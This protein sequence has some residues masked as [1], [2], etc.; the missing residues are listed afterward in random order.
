MPRLPVGGATAAD[1]SDP[2]PTRASRQFTLVQALRGLAALWVVL[3]HASATDDFPTLEAALPAPVTEWLFHAG[4]FGVAI[5][6]ALSGFVIA[7]SLRSVTF[8]WGLLGRFTLRR[9][10][11][12]DPPYW[13]SIILVTAFAWLSAYAKHEPFALPAPGQVAAHLLYLQELLRI[14]ELNA[15]YWTLTYEIQFY[16]FFVLVLVATHMILAPK[17]AAAAAWG[18]FTLLALAG[19]GGLF[20]HLLPGLFLSLWDAFFVG[21]LAYAASVHREATYVLFALVAAML[22]RA[23]ITGDGFAAISALTGVL[24]YASL[25]FNFAETALSWRGLQFLGAISYSLY[26]VHNPVT[27]AATF[28]LGHTGLIGSAARELLSLLI[29]ITATIVSATLFWVAVER[30]SHR[31]SRRIRMDRHR[32]RDE[33]LKA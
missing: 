11:R 10:L 31:L 12:L 25:R 27:G 17:R 24:F 2:R 21:A 28:L 22:A 23:A 32:Q 30:P 18:L 1:T 9:S 6:F 20:G 33:S 7:Y 14:P 16:L 26:L 15:V 4:H 13:A 8:S 3:F 29:V 19:A 5:F